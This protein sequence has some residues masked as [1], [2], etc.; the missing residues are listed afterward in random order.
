VVRGSDLLKST[1]RQI[2]LQRALN[3]LTPD[4]FHTSLI[5]DENGTRLA[6]RHDA[7]AIRTLRERNLTPAEVLAM[8]NP[9]LI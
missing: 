1:A 4:Y 9:R 8:A 3:L 7:L 6:K 2:L 5:T